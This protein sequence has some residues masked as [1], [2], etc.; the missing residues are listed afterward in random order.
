MCLCCLYG[1]D[2]EELCKSVLPSRLHLFEAAGLSNIAE[3]VV[4]HAGGS[5][6]AIFKQEAFTEF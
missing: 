5:V 1:L 6:K 2:E 4:L 3:D